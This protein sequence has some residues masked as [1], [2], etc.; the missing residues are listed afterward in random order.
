MTIAADGKPR[1]GD[2]LGLCSIEI[3]ADGTLEADFPNIVSPKKGVYSRTV[4]LPFSTNQPRDTWTTRLQEH[5]YKVIAIPYSEES[6]VF[7]LEILRDD[8]LI[9]GAQQFYGICGAKKAPKNHPPGK[10]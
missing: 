3:K 7:R 10:Q 1:Y 8:K 6:Y 4:K 2:N 5:T 9:G